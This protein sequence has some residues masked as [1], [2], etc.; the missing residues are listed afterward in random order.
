MTKIVKENR[1]NELLQEEGFFLFAEMLK[2]D[3]ELGK[4]LLRLFEKYIEEDSWPFS[5]IEV[6]KFKLPEYIGEKSALFLNEFLKIIDVNIPADIDKETGKFLKEL[7]TLHGESVRA[8]DSWL[9][10]PYQLLNVS[11]AIT[12]E[13][14]TFVN[15][16]RNDM[17]S[18]SFHVRGESLLFLIDNFVSQLEIYLKRTGEKV[19]NSSLV[20]IARAIDSIKEIQLKGDD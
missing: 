3:L 7:H 15:L 9:E 1:V 12:D 14:K 17:S 5:L 20:N 6:L 8:A 19:S 10:E 18:L 4:K 13:N 11:Y 16:K 2:E